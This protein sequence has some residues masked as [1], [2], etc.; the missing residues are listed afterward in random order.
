VSGDYESATDNLSMEI[1]Q[2]VIKCIGQTSSRVPD[3][4]WDLARARS[5]SILFNGKEKGEQLRGQLMGTFLSFPLLC[6][7]NYLVFR[8]LVP[9]PVPVRINGD[10]IVFRCRPD[11]AERWMSGVSGA[12]LVLSRGKT[13]VNEGVFTLNSALFSGCRK[14]CKALPYVRSKAL[15]TMPSSLSALAGQFQ[16]LCPGF[17]GSCRRRWQIYF[18]R[19]TARLVWA[20]QRSLTRGL[21]L[22]VSES[23]IRQ[24]GLSRRERFYLSF[25]R[26]EPLPS[27]LLEYDH[28]P[29]PVGYRSYTRVEAGL[30]RRDWAY[31]RLVEA[32]FHQSCRLSACLPVVPPSKGVEDFELLRKGTIRFWEPKSHVR[33]LFERTWRR[34]CAPFSVVKGPGRGIER[35]MLPLGEEEE[36]QRKGVGWVKRPWLDGA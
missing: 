19:R 33:R 14:G 12:G 32:S 4:V 23:V 7:I 2:H 26:E 20:S 8:W 3:S 27:P 15:F 34:L 5:Q 16:S 1:S 22:A 11:E 30:S 35:L 17:F 10:D 18:L 36:G 6:L 25:D 24:S 9:R 31:A 13:L 28:T 29:H 21:G